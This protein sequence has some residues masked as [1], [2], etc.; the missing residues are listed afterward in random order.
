[1][2][3]RRRFTHCA[4]LRHEGIVSAARDLT[5]ESRLHRQSKQRLV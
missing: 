1:M 2:D 4:R 3:G 5:V